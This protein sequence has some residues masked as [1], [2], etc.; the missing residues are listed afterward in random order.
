MLGHDVEYTFEAGRPDSI[1]KE[2][3]EVL[4][5]H[6]V[7]RI[8]INP[9]SMN[10]VTLQRIGRS[11]SE[12][13]VFKA[14][15][16]VRS[17]GF[18]NINTDIILALPGEGPAEVGRTA[19]KI[20]QLAPD[21]LTV[22]SLAIKRAAAMTR[23]MLPEDL[24]EED[25]E[26][27]VRCITDLANDLEMKPYYMYRQQNMAGNLENVGYAREGKESLYNVVIMEEVQDIIAL[28]A[29]ASS[30]FIYKDGRIER[31]INVKSINDYISRNDEMIERKRRL[32]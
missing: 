7:N 25:T 10:E 18:D 32:L 24:T 6:G 26:R 8:S 19:E 9:Q 23:S 15:E 27:M 1:S 28:G 4:K 16:V 12:D 22:H 29:G 13:D 20:R 3:L 17:I 31:A 11:H 2:K 21:S 5:K 30:K 14:F